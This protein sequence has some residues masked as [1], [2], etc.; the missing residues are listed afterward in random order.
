M[1]RVVIVGAGISG[2]S[3]AHRLQQLAPAAT[4]TVLDAADR[5]GGCVRTERHGGFT[6]ECGPNG[7]LDSN[8]STARLCRD[9]AIDDRLVAASESSGRHRYLFLGGRLQPLP[10]GLLPLLRSPLLSLRGKLELLAEP[11]RAR[12]RRGGPE[13][14]AAFARR[15]AG[16]EAAAVF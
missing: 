7:F 13:S 12:R 6:V 8:P 16:R 14:V 2:L 11:V 5:V 10:N 4:V 1:A 9:L 3:L 15:R